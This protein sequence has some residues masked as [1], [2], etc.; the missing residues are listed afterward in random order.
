MKRYIPSSLRNHLTQSLIIYVKC[1]LKSAENVELTKSV[2][3]DLCSNRSVEEYIECVKQAS[4]SGHIDTARYV[5]IEFGSEDP[6]QR[7]LEGQAKLKGDLF[8]LFCVAYFDVYGATHNVFGTRVAP[9]NQEGWDFEATNQH[10]TRCLIQAKYVYAGAFQGD[11]KTFWAESA[12][13]DG[14][15]HR[16]GSL[17]SIL[18]TSAHKHNLKRKELKETFAVIDRK[19][20]QSRCDNAGFWDTFNNDYMFNVFKMCFE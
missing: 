7:R 14:V 4:E 2:F 3:R 11:L 8:E 9:R 20:L 13:E 16:R 5:D 19:H 10:G 1:C 6:E 15:A 17:S 18:I 12:T